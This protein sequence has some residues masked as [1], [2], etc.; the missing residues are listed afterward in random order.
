MQ[1]K[2]GDAQGTREGTEKGVRMGVAIRLSL[3]G[4][5]DTQ[6]TRTQAIL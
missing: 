4:Q 3:A 2:A 6:T 1:K 5:K